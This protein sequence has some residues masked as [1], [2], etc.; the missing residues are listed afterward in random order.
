ML[1]MHITVVYEFRL[2]SFH[3]LNQLMY[4]ESKRTHTQ[5]IDEPTKYN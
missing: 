5:A 1:V 3:E 2:V 4:V